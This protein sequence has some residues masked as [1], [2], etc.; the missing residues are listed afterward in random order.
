VDLEEVVLEAWLG[1][2]SPVVGVVALLLDE[3][4]GRCI[5]EERAGGRGI[6]DGEVP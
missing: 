3:Y 4:V 2:A 5:N 6:I 1:L